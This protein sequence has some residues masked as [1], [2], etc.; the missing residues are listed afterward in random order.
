MKRPKFFEDL[1]RSIA[2]EPEI[3]EPSPQ[4]STYSDQLVALIQ[5]QRNAADQAYAMRAARANL[6]RL[7]GYSGALGGFLDGIFGGRR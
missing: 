2:G 1:E 5:M 7:G 3:V 4:P 6:E